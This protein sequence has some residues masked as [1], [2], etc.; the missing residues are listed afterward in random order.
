MS[1]T[2][3]S[4][5]GQMGSGESDD[6]FYNVKL[7]NTQTVNECKDL[8]NE[9][10]KKSYSPQRTKVTYDYK[11]DSSSDDDSDNVSKKSRGEE[12]EKAN[13][14]KE[15]EC[16]DDKNK[17]PQSTS[18]VV[19]KINEE[20]KSM[21]NGSINNKVK[22]EKSDGAVSSGKH[23][24]TTVGVPPPVVVVPPPMLVQQPVMAMGAGMI[25]PPAIGIANQMVNPTSMLNLHRGP[26]TLG[27]TI[28]GMGNPNMIQSQ[29]NVLGMTNDLLQLQG[30][31]MGI[32]G[33][34][35]QIPG[36]AIPG[37][38]M[39]GN[40]IP[41]LQAVGMQ[42][43]GANLMTNQ[44]SLIT[45]PGGVLMNPAMTV[46]SLMNNQGSMIANPGN[47]M[48]N[49]VGHQGSRLN[50]AGS[51]LSAQALNN[52]ATNIASDASKSQVNRLEQDWS[53]P[54]RTDRDS[55]S[56]SPSDSDSKND[57]GDE[58]EEEEEEEEED[59]TFRN[60]RDVPNT[61]KN[62]GSF[63]ELFKK[64]SEAN[65]SKASSSK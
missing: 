43:A 36:S 8:K 56:P 31:I 28:M 19:E 45:A 7:P 37:M 53:K 17:L 23:I 25:V 18:K 16:T 26:A 15:E 24:P 21:K 55:K 40:M 41:T 32:P 2:K 22:V 63:M 14:Q 12:R 44:G 64:M 4:S 11:F 50:Y 27:S 38:C 54:D 20:L 58:E 57:D 52:V 30:N 10:V 47:I 34:M 5:E 33:N 42:T 9:P 13:D 60:P 49:M 48:M 35:M 59:D 1:V 62:D 6:E 3:T 65:S 61:F 46:P 39:T 29:G 51:M